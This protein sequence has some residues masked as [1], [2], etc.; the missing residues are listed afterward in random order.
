MAAQR[1]DPE[2]LR[3]RAVKFS[4]PWQIYRQDFRRGTLASYRRSGRR[5]P[6]RHRSRYSRPSRRALQWA[7][8]MAQPLRLPGR[9]G[10]LPRGLRP[11]RRRDQ[12]R[13][14]PP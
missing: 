9:C 1:K 4:I 11:G 12:D 3:D 8:L 10:I 7:A 2:E 13:R 14:A 5:A 6:Y